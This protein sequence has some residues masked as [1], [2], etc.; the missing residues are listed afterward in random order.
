[1]NLKI[2]PK[3]CTYQK[4]R[5]TARYKIHVRGIRKFCLQSHLKI[6]F[7]ASK[8]KI[9]PLEGLQTIFKLPKAKFFLSK[10]FKPFSSFQ[11]QNFFSRRTSN[12]F[13]AS[14]IKIF[15]IEGLQTVF[16]LPKS[17]FFLAKGFKLIFQ[18]KI[19]FKL[20]SNGKSHLTHGL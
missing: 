4:F 2:T 15:P 5:V 3:I 9:F 12:R 8:S 14:K 19:R 20:L 11:K 18:P 17:K 7:Q 13:Q 1:M 10:D 6:T 16:K